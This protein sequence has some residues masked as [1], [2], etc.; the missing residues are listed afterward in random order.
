MNALKNLFK[1]EPVVAGAGAIIA[2]A[3]AYL[4]TSG[5]MTQDGAD[6]IAAMLT[7]V[8]GVPI[9]AGVR[10]KVSPVALPRDEE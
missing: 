8:L 2:A 5:A 1:N 9:A 4:V 7:L 10:S 6:L 3:F